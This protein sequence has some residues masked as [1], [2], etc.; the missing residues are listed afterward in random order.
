MNKNDMKMVESCQKEGEKLENERLNYFSSCFFPEHVS[1]ICDFLF[2]NQN[3]IVPKP[4]KP[5]GC[6][7]KCST[8]QGKCY[9]TTRGKSYGHHCKCCRGWSGPRANYDQTLKTYLA[10]YCDRECPFLGEGVP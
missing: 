8:S 3:C 6:H 9:L 7:P 1:L 4:T 10:L 5:P 2:R